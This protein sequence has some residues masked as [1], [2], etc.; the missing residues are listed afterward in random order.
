MPRIR[1]EVMRLDA[2][3]GTAELCGTAGGEALAF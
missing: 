1:S 2:E 3:G